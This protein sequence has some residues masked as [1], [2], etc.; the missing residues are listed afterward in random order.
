MRPFGVLNVNKPAGLTSRDVV[1]RVQRLVKPHRVGHAGTLD[2]MATGVLVLCVGQATRLI[3]YVQ[4]QK[5]RYIATF[6]LGRSSDTEDVTGEVT[7][8][9][10][11]S[12]P[13]AREVETTLLDFTGR[14]TQVPPA[15]SAL[16]IK[17]QRAYKLAR[18]GKQVVLE[19]RSIEIYDLQLLRYAYPEW[20]VDIACSS[21]TYVRSLGR[22]IAAALGTG[23]VMSALERTAVGPFTVSNAIDIEQLTA[24][25]VIERLLPPALALAELCSLTLSHDQISQIVFGKWLDDPR[26][27]DIFAGEE[28]GAASRLAQDVAA[29][30]TR[31]RLVA[32][33]RPRGDRKLVPIRNFLSPQDV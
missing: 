10:S 16:K 12:K 33:L 17:G 8:E 9:A 18:Q 27:G 15:F 13:S 4:Q 3:E 5:K 22:D 26:A 2:P 28:H 11:P 1:N 19:P 30:D 7:L 21:G 31:Q 29:F 6:L 32:I 24:D 23:A 20:A 14:I 25:N